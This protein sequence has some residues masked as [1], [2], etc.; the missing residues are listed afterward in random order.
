VKLSN[1]RK[2]FRMKEIQKRLLKFAESK[3]LPYLIILPEFK[4]Y[5]EKLSFVLVCKK[6]DEVIQI[7]SNEAISQ[8]FRIGL[9]KPDIRHLE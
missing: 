4:N 3:C 2:G 1:A 8:G 6:I 9:E 5:L 7:I